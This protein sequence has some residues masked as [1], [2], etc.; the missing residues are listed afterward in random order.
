MKRILFVLMFVLLVFPTVL[1][2]RPNDVGVYKYYCTRDTDGDIVK[3]SQYP[4]KVMAV[5]LSTNFFG[6]SQTGL[7]YTEEGIT[8]I[9]PSVGMDFSYA[10]KNNGWYIFKQ[11]L[12]MMGVNL[13]YIDV[14]YKRIRVKMSYYNGNYRE[15]VRWKESDDID[16]SPTE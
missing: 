15:Y 8:G 13:I 5:I 3:D 1:A 14:N 9:W 10:G 4:Q 11:N 6:I 12:G 16:Y 7:T 2:Q